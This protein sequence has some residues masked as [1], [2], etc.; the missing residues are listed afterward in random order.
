MMTLP[1]GR[2]VSDAIAARVRCSG[3]TTAWGT[4]S[5]R[6][7]ASS[8]DLATLVRKAKERSASAQAAGTQAQREKPKAPI[9]TSRESTSRTRQRSSTTVDRPGPSSQKDRS[10]KAP[11]IE[12]SNTSSSIG[13]DWVVTSPKLN[14][15]TMFVKVSVALVSLACP[16]TFILGKDVCAL[17]DDCIS[18]QD[19]WST[20]RS[21]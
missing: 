8:P 12:S 11:A 20:Q 1:F 15:D 2:R 5:G 4:R 21:G 13:S 9:G 18:K 7:T 17:K 19:C 10:M 16:V 3:T 6:R 14:M